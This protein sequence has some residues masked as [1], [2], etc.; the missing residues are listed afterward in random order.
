MIEKLVND[1]TVLATAAIV[2]GIIL[3]AAVIDHS[4]RQAKNGR[5]PA[6][7]EEIEFPVT[8]HGDVPYVEAQVDRICLAELSRPG[9]SSVALRCGLLFG[10]QPP[11]YDPL[12][13]L[14]FLTAAELRVFDGETYHGSA[15]EKARGR[16]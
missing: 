2:V 9:V 7:F 3:A 10:H 5:R 15:A 4:R 13:K 16:S 12:E 8:P 11:H 1:P 6:E 14:D